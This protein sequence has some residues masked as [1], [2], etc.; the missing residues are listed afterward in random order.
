MTRYLNTVPLAWKRPKKEVA[1]SRHAGIITAMNRQTISFTGLIFLTL[2]LVSSAYSEDPVASSMQEK[3]NRTWEIITT[4]TEVLGIGESQL[5]NLQAIETQLR[6]SII[7]AK[8]EESL[9]MID[10]EEELAQPKPDQGKINPL[11]DKKM[12]IKGLLAKDFVSAL[13]QIKQNLSDKQEKTLIELEQK[14][15]GSA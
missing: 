2:T 12:E 7:R 15:Y 6:R 13:I 4:Q 9:L 14:E 11:I 10:V 5:K 3:F 1:P 8:A